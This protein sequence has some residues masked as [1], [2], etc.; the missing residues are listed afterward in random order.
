MN[1]AEE[2]GGEGDLMGGVFLSDHFKKSL[3]WVQGTTNVGVGNIGQ[4]ILVYRNI[5]QC[6]KILS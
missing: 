6:E 2:G 5:I 1:R 4:K 3:V